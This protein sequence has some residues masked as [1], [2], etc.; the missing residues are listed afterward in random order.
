MPFKLKKGMDSGWVIV[1]VPGGNVYQMLEG[2]TKGSSKGKVVKTVLA[3]AQLY[4][5][6]KRVKG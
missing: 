3:C 4:W 5:W 2:P 6:L 1:Y